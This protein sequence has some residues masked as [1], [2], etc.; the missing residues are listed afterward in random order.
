M[1]NDTVTG[2]D[3]DRLLAYLPLVSPGAPDP[4]ER[5]RGDDQERQD[6]RAAPDALA[7]REIPSTDLDSRPG[8]RTIQYVVR[9]LS[10]TVGP[11]SGLE[12]RC[13]G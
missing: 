2:A 1:A 10:G 5:L 13:L 3:I 8:R 7:R 12:R 9:A 4:V 6:C 11:A